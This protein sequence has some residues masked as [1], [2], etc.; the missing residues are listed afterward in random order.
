MLPWEIPPPQKKQNSG[1]MMATCS[2]YDLEYKIRQLIWT[3]LWFRGTIRGEREGGK[4]CRQKWN[5]AHVWLQRNQRGTN[6]QTEPKKL[7]VARTRSL[8]PK[9]KTQASP[10][11]LCRPHVASLKRTLFMQHTCMQAI[12]CSQYLHYTIKCLHQCKPYHV[13]GTFLLFIFY[14]NEEFS[15]GSSLNCK[16]KEN[17]AQQFYTSYG[18]HQVVGKT[19]NHLLW[20]YRDTYCSICDL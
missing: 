9:P 17:K 20:Y 2:C 13:H 19:F 5:G 18:F 16:S 3:K 4:T 14:S 7:S 12:S 10:S 6:W 1:I 15:Q 8:E 11:M